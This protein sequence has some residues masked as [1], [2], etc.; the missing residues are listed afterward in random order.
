MRVKSLTTRNFTDGSLTDLRMR[1]KSSIWRRSHL[2]DA[3][4]LGDL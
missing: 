4:R 1:A 2:A 3:S